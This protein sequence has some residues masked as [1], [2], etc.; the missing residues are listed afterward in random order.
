MADGGG[1]RPAGLAACPVCG[2][3]LFGRGRCPN[4][5]CRRPDRAFSVAF[6]AGRYDGAL[7]GAIVR[8][9]Y[10][11]ELWWAD[12]FAR[13]VAR[14]LQ[15]HATWFEDFDLIVPVPSYVGAGG[16]RTWDPVGRIAVALQRLVNPGWEVAPGAVVKWSETPAMQGRDWPSRQAIAVGPLRQSLVVPEPSTVARARILVFDDVLTDG[17]TLRE[18][19]RTLRA[20]G[21]REVAGLVLARPPWSPRSP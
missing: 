5:W 4:R 20:A 15:E 17:S 11:R 14:Y 9:K 12:V 16:R 10:R 7:R 19:A 13:M 21:A 2:Q 1:P 18:V 3:L 8:Y 6:A